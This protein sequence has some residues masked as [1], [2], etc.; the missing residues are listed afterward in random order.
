[1]K[2]GDAGAGRSSRAFDPGASSREASSFKKRDVMRSWRVNVMVACLAGCGPA[3]REAPIL[4]SN[5][6]PAP[7]TYEDRDWATVLGENV[8]DGRVDYAR[9][10]RNLDPLRAYLAR[11]E[12]VGPRSTPSLFPSEDHDLAYHVNVYNACVIRAVLLEDVPPTVYALDDA[13]FERRH[14]FLVDGRLQTLADLRATVRRLAGADV[15]VEFCL[16]EPA[17]GA[18]PLPGAPLR[19]EE[20]DRQL[21]EIT[22]HALQN[23]RVVQVDREGGRLLVALAI[24]E[25]RADFIRFAKG[26][27]RSDLLGALGFL[28]GPRLRPAFDAAAGF[29]V[30]P[31]P[32]DN[33]LNRT[34]GA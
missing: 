12:R 23:P 5:D 10:R 24:H 32:F 16:C 25:R 28:A 1:M 4:S 8:S 7:R 34:P 29:R 31:L 3:I 30:E 21:N 13:P 26:S 18:P 20:L 6:A 19:P 33:R 2:H 15:R 9:L 27:D 11:V 17:L 22:R 14:K